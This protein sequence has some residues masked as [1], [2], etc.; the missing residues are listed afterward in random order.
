MAVALE[1]SS[2]A[3]W[4]GCDDV[5]DVAAWAA[6]VQK[7]SCDERDGS[8]ANRALTIKLQGVQSPYIAFDIP[9]D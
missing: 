6:L 2:G 4:V 1:D 3:I 8:G 5:I 7:R 9:Y